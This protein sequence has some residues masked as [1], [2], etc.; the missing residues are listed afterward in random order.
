MKL[1]NT[2]CDARRYHGP[3]AVSTPEMFGG[4]YAKG[5]RLIKAE[6]D[7]REATCLECGYSVIKPSH[8]IDTAA[9]W[10]DKQ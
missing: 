5:D 8:Q 7:T 2:K 9:E 1:P 4:M 3:Y 10:R 6:P